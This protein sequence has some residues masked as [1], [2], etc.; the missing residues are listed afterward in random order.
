MSQIVMREMFDA[1]EKSGNYVCFEFLNASVGFYCDDNDFVEWFS[2]YFGGYFVP[3]QRKP[4]DAVIYSS[5]DASLFQDLHTL[6]TSSGH[7]EAADYTE[8]RLDSQNSL[9]STREVDKKN[10]VDETC[11]LVSQA[12][13]RVLVAS[14]GSVKARR[15]TI[16]RTLRNMMK[17]LLIERGWLPLHASACVKNGVGIC[18]LGGKFAGKTSTLINLLSQSDA[19]LV[20]NDTLFLRDAGTHVEGCGFPNKAGLRIGTLLANPELLQWI[21][22]TSDSFYPQ[23]DAKTVRE[24]VATTPAA[25][26]GKRPEKIILLATELA[27]ML[28]IA[29]QP[30][31]PIQ[32]FLAVQFDPALNEA[33]LV[34]VDEEQIISQLAPHFRSL[35]AEKQGFLQSLFDFNETQLRM[36]FVSLMTKYASEVVL[37]ELHQNAGTN[38]HAE[39]LVDALTREYAPA[40]ENERMLSATGPL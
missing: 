40:V 4:A 12:G 10:N 17:L 6:A 16:K 1:L 27:E 15:A 3:S 30:I 8:L 22:K 24:I 34:P 5:Q 14:P 38:A 18:I 35:S 37:R 32:L 2:K 31:T 9:I 36:K 23:I 25:E 29:I 7:A 13:K 28:Q 33:R 20:S 19:T 21:G 11:Y 26:L 39:A